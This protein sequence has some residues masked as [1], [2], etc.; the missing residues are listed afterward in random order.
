MTHSC[1]ADIWTSLNVERQKNCGST[2]VNG[3]TVSCTPSA[4]RPQEIPSQPPVFHVPETL[5]PRVK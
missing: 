4:Y 2:L 3:K 1:V 5:K